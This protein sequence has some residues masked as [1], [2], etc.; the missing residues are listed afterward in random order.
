LKF[1]NL[2][3]DKKFSGPN[4]WSVK[5]RKM[6]ISDTFF[7]TSS[8]EAQKLHRPPKIFVPFTE[9]TLLLKEQRKSGLRA[10]SKA[11]LTSVAL[12]VRG[13]HVVDLVVYG[14]DY[15]L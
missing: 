15:P 5:L 8:V 3:Y 1:S 9:K 4:P 14:G 7:F 10:T 6:N 11:M 13:G 12:R 2:S